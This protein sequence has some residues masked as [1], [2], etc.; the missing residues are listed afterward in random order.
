ML[1]GLVGST[2]EVREEVVQRV[3]NMSIV[4]P[5]VASLV[6]LGRGVT[7]S[8]V[9][10]KLIESR[11]GAMIITHVMTEG[12]S[13]LIRR[14]GGILWHMHGD[15]SDKIEF[16]IHQDVWVSLEENRPKHF[17]NVEQAYSVQII[18]HRSHNAS[19][20]RRRAA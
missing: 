4:R 6:G 2:I 17:Y 20:Y 3:L 15:V 19:S 7:R 18:K 12:E 1:I 5:H 14:K 16:D 11:R 9:L 8:R 13:D 10:D